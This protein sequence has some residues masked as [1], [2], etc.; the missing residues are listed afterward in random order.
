VF[1]CTLELARKHL[2]DAPDHKLDTLRAHLELE[3]GGHR[4]LADAAATW[5]VL[6]ACVE[7]AGAPRT[8]SAW[9]AGRGSPLTIARRMPG[10]PRMSQ[11]LR[12]LASA[13]RD[14]QE[15]ALLYGDGEGP[16]AALRV[17]PRFLFER[18]GKGYLE[19]ECL[20]SGLLKTY[21]LE[22]VRNVVD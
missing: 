6:E 2:P 22:K 14:R 15:V 19:A 13:V 4:A 18:R 21:L 7:Q 5:K 12:R 8:A 20:A 17:L 9:L 1:L 11:R 3:D 10:P 16:P